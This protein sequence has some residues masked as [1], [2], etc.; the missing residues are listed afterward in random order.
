M[1][2]WDW[3]SIICAIAVSVLCLTLVFSVR[4][5]EQTRHV[6]EEQARLLDPFD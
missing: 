3:F 1:N 5:D 6:K 4:S 2:V